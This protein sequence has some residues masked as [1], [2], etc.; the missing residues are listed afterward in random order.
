MSINFPFKIHFTFEYEQTI[1]TQAIRP[2]TTT[3]LY[4]ELVISSLME[5]T[6]L[7]SVLFEHLILPIAWVGFI[8]IYLNFVNMIARFNMVSE[9]C[10]FF[11]D[12]EFWFNLWENDDNMNESEI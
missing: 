1:L 9:L 12:P 8:H 6:K 7:K 11:C 5:R 3:R 2:P 4:G 10:F